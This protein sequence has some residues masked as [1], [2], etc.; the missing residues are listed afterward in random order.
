MP[1]CIRFRYDSDN[2]DVM[3]SSPPTTS[4]IEDG[5]EG[6]VVGRQDSYGGGGTSGGL[7]Q[8][9]HSPV[10]RGRSL[11]DADSICLAQLNGLR[12]DVAGVDGIK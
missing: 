11:S 2:T 6:V 9:P 12:Q 5:S 7:L 1:V 8:P 4:P 3:S 10:K